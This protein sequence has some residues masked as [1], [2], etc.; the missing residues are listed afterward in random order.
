MWPRPYLKGNQLCLGSVGTLL[1]LLSLCLVHVDS[2]TLGSS[3]GGGSLAFVYCLSK[4]CL[5]EGGLVLRCGQCILYDSG[6]G[7]A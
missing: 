3:P 4:L 1:L 7:G 2:C 6:G 5:C